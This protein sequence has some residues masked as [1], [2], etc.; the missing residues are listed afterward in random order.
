MLSEEKKNQE[1]KEEL[2]EEEE[3]KVEGQDGTEKPASKKTAESGGGPTFK[4]QARS[5]AAVAPG[6][7]PVRPESNNPINYVGNG[8]SL[9]DKVREDRPKAPTT[10]NS[11]GRSRNP[12]ASS[13]A[14]AKQEQGSQLSTPGAVRSHSAVPPS[15]HINPSSKYRLVESLR[16]PESVTAQDTSLP[17]ENI[18]APKGGASSGDVEQPAPLPMFKD[19]SRSVIAT[20]PGAL[21]SV[22][23]PPPRDPSPNASVLPP[24]SNDSYPQEMTD[25]T[26]TTEVEDEETGYKETVGYLVEAELVQ[27]EEK[28]PR[29]DSK[30]TMEADVYFAENVDNL[31]V[32]NRR[33]LVMIVAAVLL[34]LGIILGGVCGSGHCKPDVKVVVDTVDTSACTVPAPEFEIDTNSARFQGLEFLL[35]EN[36]GAT[37]E[38]LSENDPRMLALNWVSNVDPVHPQLDVDGTNFP[39]L[40]QRYVLAVFYFSTKGWCWDQ[41]TNWLNG[42]SECSWDTVQC[43][44]DGTNTVVNIVS[45]A[46]NIRGTLPGELSYLD[47]LKLL[48]FGEFRTA[49]HCFLFV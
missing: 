13:S 2:E 4:D 32:R 1:C 7:V 41:S 19:Q 15:D 48:D 39:R 16:H 31:T 20:H 11:S 47:D 42:A 12:P 36:Y 45:A 10:T 25:E 18:L 9:Q 30:R 46:N 35:F 5:V 3:G 8:P 49:L 14:V 37:F 40:R 34:V 33:R 6:A 27:A 29:K 43:I 23:S 24:T 44:D 21:P 26:P 38:D 17:E 28:L 22:P